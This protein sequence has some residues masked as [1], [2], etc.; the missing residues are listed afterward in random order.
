MRGYFILIRNVFF[1]KQ[2]KYVNRANKIEF[3]LVFSCKK[4]LKFIINKFIYKF[5]NKF[6]YKFNKKDMNN[7]LG[8]LC[9]FA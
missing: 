4:I 9:L 6:I 1:A 8:C 5:I 7:K 3:S 2:L